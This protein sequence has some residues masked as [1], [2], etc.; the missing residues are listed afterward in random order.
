MLGWRIRDDLTN[1]LYRGTHISFVRHVSDLFM[2]YSIPKALF[3][4]VRT[5]VGGVNPGH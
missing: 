5:F 3:A 4:A 1:V 2:N